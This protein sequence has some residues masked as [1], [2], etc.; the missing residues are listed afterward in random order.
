MSDYEK[1]MRVKMVSMQDRLCPVPYG[2]TG[3]IKGSR[4]EVHG[5]T[6]ITKIYVSWDNGQTLPI[7]LP[8]DSFEYIHQPGA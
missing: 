5:G 2:T 4:K 1:G 6:T 3:T 8:F 7:C